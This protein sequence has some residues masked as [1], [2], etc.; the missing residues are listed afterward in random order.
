MLSI[1]NYSKHY[2]NFDIENLS[3]DIPDGTVVGLI[4]ENGAGKSTIIKSILGVVHSDSGHILFNGTE[5]SKISK[6]E[7]QQI[8]F[9]L[10]DTGLPMELNLTMLCNVLSCIYDKWDAAKF[11]E[12][13][14]RFSLPDKK[15]LKEFSK[16][17]KMK[18]AIAVAL[19]YDSRL[20]ILDEPT[21]GLDLFHMR[22]VASVVGK[23]A[24]T[25]RTALVVTHDPEFIL[26]CCNY[27][28]HLENGQIQE[29]YSIENNDG[30][31]RLLKFFLNDMEKEVRY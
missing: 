27:V 6:K 25:G 1:K 10:D 3:F 12:L 23:V 2:K 19:S 16:G 8:S 11:S 15:A 26:R 5:I 31:N 30:R 29:S 7:R 28:L 17:M 22:Q 18:A 24:D 21:S 4:G 20:L 14:R 13:I 9:V